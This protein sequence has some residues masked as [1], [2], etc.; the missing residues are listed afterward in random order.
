MGTFKTGKNNKADVK[1][2][3]VKPN[4]GPGTSYDPRS[5]IVKPSGGHMSKSNKSKSYFK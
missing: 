2:T 5:P 4:P 1:Q 3:R